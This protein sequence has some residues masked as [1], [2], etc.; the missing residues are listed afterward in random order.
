MGRCEVKWLYE[1]IYR[2]EIPTWD[3]GPRKELVDLVKSG[4]VQSCSTVCLRSGTANN[5]IFLAQE[6]FDVTAVDY[7]KSAVELGQK[8]AQKAG[9]PIRFFRDDLTNLRHLASSLVGNI[10]VGNDSTN[11]VQI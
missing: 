7:A 10:T 9:V 2:Y 6:A 8:R 1:F 5:A 3:I 4:R 11:T